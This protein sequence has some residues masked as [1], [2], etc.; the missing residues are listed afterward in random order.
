MNGKKEN[1]RTK[2]QLLPLAKSNIDK[3]EDRDE[4]IDVSKCKLGKE[5]DDGFECATAILP[6]SS[7][8]R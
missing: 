1:N 4:S 8:F 7:N 5:S 3:G 6:K 2:W